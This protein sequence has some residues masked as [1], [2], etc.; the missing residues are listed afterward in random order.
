LVMWT[1]IV[2]GYAAFWFGAVMLIASFGRSSAT[3]AVA[4]SS[5]WLL[6]VVVLPSTLNMTVSSLYPMPSRVDMLAALRVA[7]RVTAGKG[8]QLLAKYYGDHPEL[9]AVTDLERVANDVAVTQLAIDEEIERQVRPVVDQYDVQLSRQQ[10]AIDRFRLL[11][12]AVIAQ[13]ALNDVAGTGS[14]RYQHFV[15]IVEDY[16]EGWQAAFASMIVAKQRLTPDVYDGLPRF[17]YRDESLRSVL[18]RVLG[19]VG[20][21]AAGGMA[22]SLIGAARLSRY[23]AA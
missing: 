21:L 19:A 10:S 1:A 16:H 4:L 22:L 11:S 6:L 14:A 23:H 18:S 15:S 2:T 17:S 12:P 9:V 8:N 20:V 5:L 7:T 13:D 3:N